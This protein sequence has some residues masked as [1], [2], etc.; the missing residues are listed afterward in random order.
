MPKKSEQES[1][2]AITT[3][4]LENQIAIVR[5]WVE[6]TRRLDELAAKLRAKR[7]KP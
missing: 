4:L 5:A 7:V 3:L 2:S 6:V 1:N